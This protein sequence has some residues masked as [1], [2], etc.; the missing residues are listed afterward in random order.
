MVQEINSR[1]W[2]FLATL[3]EVVNLDII[4]ELY[5]N[6]KP[7]DDAPLANVYG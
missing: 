6:T 7:I 1:G 4:K 5:A 2:G 3:S